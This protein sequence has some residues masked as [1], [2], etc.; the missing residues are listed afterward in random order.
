MKLVALVCGAL[1]AVAIACG[2][3]R[4]AAPATAP[5][6]T[7]QPTPRM[8]IDA[9]SSKIDADLAVLGMVRPPATTAHPL[10]MAPSPAA[11]TAPPG[12][13]CQSVC[14]LGESICSNAGRIC[15]I[16]G[17]LDSTDAYANER[18]ASATASCTA[19]RER[20]CGCA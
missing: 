8:E 20:C 14:T 13:K 18:C 2:G 1:C 4:K 15:E 9:L 17:R 19:A 3:G 5:Q 16:A 10:S 12:E 7:A 11:C 6:S